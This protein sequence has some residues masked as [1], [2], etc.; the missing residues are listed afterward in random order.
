MQGFDR[1]TLDGWFLSGLPVVRLYG[2]DY[3]YNTDTYC[4]YLVEVARNYNVSVQ[5]KQLA[6][7]P[8]VVVRCY[9]GEEPEKLVDPLIVTNKKTCPW[10]FCSFKGCV[11]RIAEGYPPGS[12]CL[13][14]A[15]VK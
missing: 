9:I 2:K 14:H 12:V 6:D 7:P 15:G 11:H 10:L 1:E 3:D 8:G 4:A 13:Q 5:L